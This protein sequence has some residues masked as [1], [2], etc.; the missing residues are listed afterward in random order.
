MLFPS[1]ISVVIT[2]SVQKASSSNSFG[3]ENVSG[4]DSR[5]SSGACEYY[6]TTLFAMLQFQAFCTFMSTTTVTL[7]S[8]CLGDVT[9]LPIQLMSNSLAVGSLL[10][11][12]VLFSSL[13]TLI[14]S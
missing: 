13:W 11:L 8:I 10:Y 12:T 3:K 1:L 2:I 5:D 4:G 9:V 7:A 14:P 6:T